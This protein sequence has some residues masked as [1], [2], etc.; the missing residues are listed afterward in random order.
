MIEPQNISAEAV[1]S[2]V[3]LGVNIA[4][5]EIQ[6]DNQTNN[7]ESQKVDNKC[8]MT[9]SEW[10]RCLEASRSLLDLV[11]KTPQS[12]L[13]IVRALN[14]WKEAGRPD[15][16]E[17]PPTHR[18]LALPRWILNRECNFSESCSISVSPNSNIGTKPTCDDKV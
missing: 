1:A 11:A 18:H 6:N 16:G 8:L 9:F 5:S 10:L 17:W 2:S 15:L 14:L 3:L 13:K 12:A 4:Q 7:V